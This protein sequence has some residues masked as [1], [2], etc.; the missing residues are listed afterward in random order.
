MS[1]RQYHSSLHLLSLA[2]KQFPLIQLWTHASGS[3]GAQPPDGW[4]HEFTAVL[5]FNVVFEISRQG[6]IM[7]RA[8]FLGDLRAG[9]IVHKKTSPVLFF[10]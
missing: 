8:A 4:L 2:T 5:S 9:H 10:K 7:T 6:Q 3:D 1:P